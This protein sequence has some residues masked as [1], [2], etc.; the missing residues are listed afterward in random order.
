LSEFLVDV[1]ARRI[2]RLMVFMP[3]RHGKSEMISKYFPAWYLGNMPTERVILAS[4][5]AEFAE[6]WGRKAR[7]LIEEYGDPFFGIRLSDTIRRANWWEIA[8]YG[9][10]MFTAGVG[11]PITGKGA[12]V[13][14]IDDPVKNREEAESKTI[15][16]NTWNWWTSTAYTRLEPNGVVVLI[17]TR[18]HVDDLAGRLL[19]QQ[20][21][22]GEEWDGEPWTVLSLPAIAEENDMLGRRPGEPLW[23]DR[24]DLQR[25]LSIKAAVGPYDWFSLYQQ[26]PTPPGGAF[27][28]REHFRY[29]TER[30]G[31]YILHTGDG[32]IMYSQRDCWIFQVCDPAATRKDSGDYFVVSTWAVTPRADLLL[33]DVF[34]QRLE[35]ASHTNI[36]VQQFQRW[37]PAYQGIEEEKL[38]KVLMSNLLALGLPIRPLTPDRDKIQ[39]AI[40]ASIKYQAG[41]IYHRAGAKWLDDFEMELL[42]FPNGEFDD[43]VDNVSYAALEV[44]T[45]PDRTGV[46]KTELQEIIEAEFESHKL[47]ETG[48]V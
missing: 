8:G 38:G 45:P 33:L 40:T 23:P 19:R 18:W 17:M 47:K 31:F 39:R 3:P 46:K 44:Y 7:D 9:G 2:K 36:M 10:G 30:D 16:E 6:S 22:G 43:Q 4:Y 21:E 37:R 25:L 12:N 24:F 41:K 32:D 35:V 28:S 15:R 27:F 26:R 42:S 34:R 1:A 13:L 14:I 20:E 48:W 5:E 11:G 29:F